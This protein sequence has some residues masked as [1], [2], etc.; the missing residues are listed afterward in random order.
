MRPIVPKDPPRV[1]L[2]DIDIQRGEGTP[3]SLYGVVMK[4]H[5]QIGFG[6]TTE[7]AFVSIGDAASESTVVGE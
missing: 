7:G 3:D 5:V 4:K 2:F 6:L 1:T